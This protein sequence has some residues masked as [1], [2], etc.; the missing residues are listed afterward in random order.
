MQ[1]QPA[2]CSEDVATINPPQSPSSLIIAQ[3]ESIPQESRGSV[4]A[5]LEGQSTD[6]PSRAPVRTPLRERFEALVAE[7]KEAVG[8]ESD[9]IRMVL[10]PAYLQIIGMGPPVLPLLLREL[11]RQPDHWLVALYSIAG[12]DAAAGHDSFARAVA[13]WLEWGRERGYIGQRSLEPT[14]EKP[15]EPV[16]RR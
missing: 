2:T 7:W 8:L 3:I 5:Q 16:R 13:A 6:A 11:E 14:E 4:S 10:H 1:T 9:V 12:E 15:G